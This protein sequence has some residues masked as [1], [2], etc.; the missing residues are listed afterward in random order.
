MSA[1]LDCIVSKMLTDDEL[2]RIYWSEP[3]QA[4]LVP[5]KR[6]AT[7]RFLAVNIAIIRKANNLETLAFILARVVEAAYQGGFL[8]GLQGIEILVTVIEG[9]TAER[10]LRFSVS[11]AALHEVPRLS[12][13]DLLRPAP[14]E[15]ITCGW[16]GIPPEN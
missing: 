6:S 13:S 10:A 8:D 14:K 15:G 9:S 11:P 2:L 5:Y 7:Q 12:P 3:P 16:Y 4:C 1:N